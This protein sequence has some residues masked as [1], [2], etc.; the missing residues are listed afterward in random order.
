MDLGTFLRQRRPDWKRLEALL[1]RVE[2]SGLGALTDHEAIEFGR[3]YRHVASDLN[4][5]QTFVTGDATVQYLNDLVTRCYL[6]IYA[7]GRMDIVG[8]LLYLF[9]GYPAHFRRCARQVILAAA[10]FVAGG[11]FGFLASY[12]DPHTARSYL[13]PSDMPMIRPDRDSDEPHTTGELAAFS[14]LL[15]RNNMGVS[16]FAF[17]LGITFGVGT[18]WVL[19][20]NGI[21]FG[22]LAAVFVEA[23]QLL[24]FCTDVLPHG[25]LELPAIFI[26]GG[27]GFLLAQ[28]MIG[29]RPWPR[30]EEMARAGKQ[31][32]LL[33]AGCLPLLFIAAGLEAVVARAP[34]WYLTSGLKLATAGI[35]GAI[36]VV[37]LVAFG[38]PRRS[39]NG[40]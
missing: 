32:L 3:L 14:A 28:G 37:Y 11:L 33:V 21:L 22:T 30:L 12:F 29:A 36:F 38:W 6:V 16:L 2:G 1:R 25:V 18:A 23:G 20:H 27:A 10:F 19:F 9:W 8:F 15:F 40:G 17:A 5:A 31:S 34:D 24:R 35:F 26:A 4:Q 7:K 13:L 39:Q